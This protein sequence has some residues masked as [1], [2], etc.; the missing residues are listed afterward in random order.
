VALIRQHQEASTADVDPEIKRLL[1][2]LQAVDD[3]N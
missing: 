2:K 1:D 3:D